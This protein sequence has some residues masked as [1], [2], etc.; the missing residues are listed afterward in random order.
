MSGLKQTLML[1]LFSGTNNA[2]LLFGQ[3]LCLTFWLV[4]TCYPNGSMHRF[5][6]CF[7]GGSYQKHGGSATELQLTLHVRY[8]NISPLIIA[9]LDGAG[10]QLVLPGHQTSHQWT[11][12]SGATFKPWFTSHQLILK[13]IL[14]PVLLRQQQPG[15]FECTRRSLCCHH[16]RQLCIKVSGLCLNICSTTTFLQNTSVI[17][18][19]FQP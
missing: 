16:R 17:L 4:L 9:G 19:D 10:L 14:L 2:F 8:K 13:R 11:S 1:H 5:T 12:S 15:I 7:W 6:G 3:A 18:L